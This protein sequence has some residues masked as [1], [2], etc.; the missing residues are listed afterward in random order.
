MLA[1][2]RRLPRL[3]QR[4]RLDVLAVG[5]DG[6]L[7]VAPAARGGR[8]AAAQLLALRVHLDLTPLAPQFGHA[9]PPGQKLRDIRLQV[10]PGLHRAP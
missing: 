3:D 10:R 8:L 7:R 1:E 9:V 4:A 2:Q 5:R 6:R